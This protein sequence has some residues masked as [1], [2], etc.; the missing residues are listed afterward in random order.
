MIKRLLFALILLVIVIV[1]GTLGYMLIEKWRFLDSFYMTVIT[2]AS[3]G[4]MEVNPLSQ[5]GRIFTIF[6]II[7]GMGILLFGIST[8][9]AFLVEGE[10][11][12]ILRRRKME[13]SISGLTGHYIVCG[14]GTIGRHIIEELHQ[15]GR[16]FV[17]IDTSED[18]CRE[19]AGRG[20]LVIKGDST[21]S[22]VLRSANAAKAKGVFCSLHTD[23]ENLLLILTAK[24]INPSLRIVS[25]AEEDES[26]EKMVR[27]GADG[28]VLPKHIGG[29]RMASAMVRPEAVSFLDTM[30]KG[31]EETYRVEDVSITEDSIFAGKT[32]KES[33]LPEKRGLSVVAVKKKERYVFNPSGDER[34][35]AG[36]ALIL[37]GEIKSI[38][39]I[40]S[41]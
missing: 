16:N 4:F 9:T 3:V 38:K 22:S 13:K 1:S 14:I 11:S 20:M 31:Q 24:G 34:L 35:D 5:Q 28:V 39:E 23:A 26:E 32:L 10:L 41:A 7:F 19:S 2:I 8:F 25:K 40:R 17:A 36:D 29:L 18:V 6:L 21:S 15:T 30:L 37:I 33:G 27:A 12:E